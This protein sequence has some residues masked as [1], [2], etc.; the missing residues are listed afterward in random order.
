[1]IPGEWNAVTGY[2][3]TFPTADQAISEIKTGKMADSRGRTSTLKYWLCC[4]N[5]QVD[6]Q[7]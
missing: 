4:A 5:L 7:H 6:I 1:M 2:T 3:S